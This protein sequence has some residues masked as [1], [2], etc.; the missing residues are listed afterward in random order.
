MKKDDTGKAALAA[1]SHHVSFNSFVPG[2]ARC[3]S[4]VPDDDAVTFSSCGLLQIKGRRSVVAKQLCENRVS[5]PS[6]RN[7]R[8]LQIQHQQAHKYDY[9]NATST[10]RGSTVRGSTVRGLTVRGAHN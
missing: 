1:G 2:I 8:V 9:Y 6:L 7:I 5:L 3:V 10:V 4:D